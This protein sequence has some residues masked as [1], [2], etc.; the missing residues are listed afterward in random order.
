M[1]RRCAGGLCTQQRTPSLI[2]VL[3]L[4]NQRDTVAS[5]G[6][7]RTSSERFWT[8]TCDCVKRAF[9]YLKALSDPLRRADGGGRPVTFEL[10]LGRACRAIGQRSGRYVY[11]LGLRLT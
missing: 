6:R 11:L 10:T 4:S 9:R 2:M 3:L 5:G 8:F 7:G 1:G